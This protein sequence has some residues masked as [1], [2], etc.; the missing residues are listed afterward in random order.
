MSTN[1][2]VIKL[3]AKELEKLKA[4]A[5]NDPNIAFT[6]GE[7]YAIQK[8]EY[9][10]LKYYKIA[11]EKKHVEAMYK[12]ALHFEKCAV[13][14]PLDYT[15]KKL[16]YFKMAAECGHIESARSLIAHYESRMETYKAQKYK[17]RFLSN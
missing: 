3:T 16:K 14:S 12:M 10:M 13:N 5:P 4:L 6:V 9:K 2:D 11:V 1:T 8:D 17:K 7:Y 15:Y